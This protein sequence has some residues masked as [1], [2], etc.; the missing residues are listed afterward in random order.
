MGILKGDIAFLDEKSDLEE[1]IKKKWVLC[2]GSHWDLLKI[3]QKSQGMKG[4]ERRAMDEGVV[5]GC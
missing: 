5:G 2:E 3:L 1:D 4:E